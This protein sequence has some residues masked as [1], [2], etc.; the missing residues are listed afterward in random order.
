MLP[1]AAAMWG[2][3]GYSNTPRNT[4]EPY[5]FGADA[6]LTH[7][8]FVTDQMCDYLRRHDQRRP[9]F[10]IAG[11]YA[12]HPPLNPPQEY[13]DRV[14]RSKLRLPIVGPEDLVDPAL[15]DMTDEQWRNV[16]AAY[17]A[18]VA[19]VDDGVG[20]IIRVLKAQGIYDNTIIVFTS[21]HGEFL[22][23]HGRIQKGMPGH[24][25]IIHV[26]CIISYPKELPPGRICSALTAAVDVVPT[27]LDLCGIQIPS[28]VQGKTMRGLLQGKTDVHR[29]AVLVEYFEEHGNRQTTVRTERHKYFLHENGKELLYDLAKDCH[30]HYDVSKQPAYAD[31]L[32]Q[33]RLIMLRE[34]QQAA[35][36]GHPQ[37]DAY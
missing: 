6:S 13:L 1:P 16:V 22:G 37:T 27:L 8:A 15:Q 4:H 23:D 19:Q 14:D 7:T 11:Y 18:M 30:E 21:D 31:V 2:R 17:L 25:C 36:Y 5:V 20:E 12:P 34:V 35:Y 26:P 33:M 10:A 28:F 24:D 9:F 29:D 32:S 3:K